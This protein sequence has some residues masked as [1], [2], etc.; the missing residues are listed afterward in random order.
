MPNMT[1]IP[2]YKTA[3]NNLLDIETSLFVPPFNKYDYSTVNACNELG[4]IIVPSFYEV[5][6]KL[7]RN[8]VTTNK[9]IREIANQVKEKGNCAYHPYWLNGGWRKEYPYIGDKQYTVSEGTWN[10]KQSMVTWNRLLDNIGE[11]K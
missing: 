5:D 2:G 11:Y 3:L 7:I 4:M 1:Q 10:L 8:T 6:T 9:K